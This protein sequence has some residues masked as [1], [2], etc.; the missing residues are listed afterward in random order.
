MYPKPFLITEEFHIESVLAFRSSAMA[1][2]KCPACD[3]EWMVSDA[4][5]D[6]HTL[7]DFCTVCDVELLPPSQL[8]QQHGDGEVAVALAPQS[9]GMEKAKGE[10][11][12]GEKT[13]TAT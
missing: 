7:G 1:F 6:W 8:Q 5:K 2:R 13:K 4:D 9:S 11:A 3:S 10:E 12:K